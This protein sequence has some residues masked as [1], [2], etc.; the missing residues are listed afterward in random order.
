MG[1]GGEEGEGPREQG[2]QG[3]KKKK[4]VGDP[5]KYGKNFIKPK[6]DKGFQSKSQKDVPS[7]GVVDFDEER[8][9]EM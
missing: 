5:S 7:G 8:V 6:S 2:T 3:E 9:F 1:E 4:V